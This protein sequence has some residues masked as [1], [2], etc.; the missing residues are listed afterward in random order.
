[1]LMQIAHLPVTVCLC[2][3]CMSFLHSLLTYHEPRKTRHPSTQLTHRR[4]PVRQRDTEGFD[5]PFSVNIE[6]HEYESFSAQMRRKQEDE[7][8]KD[9]Q[10]ER[11]LLC[12]DNNAN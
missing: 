4:A 9:R 2:E 7:S 11:W 10:R 3:H 8:D 12:L 1:M 5:A 6:V